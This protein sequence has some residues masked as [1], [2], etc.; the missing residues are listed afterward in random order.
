LEIGIS[1]LLEAGEV[2]RG[3]GPTPAEQLRIFK[4]LIGI[5]IGIA[6]QACHLALGKLL[7]KAPLSEHQGKGSGLIA[8]D[9]DNIFSM[10]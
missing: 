2:R 5:D 1:P 9:G 6:K 10:N 7:G 4:L 8:L 3:G